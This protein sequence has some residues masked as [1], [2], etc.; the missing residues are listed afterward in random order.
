MHI[1]QAILAT[2]ASPKPLVRGQIANILSVIAKIEIPREEWN[3]LVP[4]LCN[5]STS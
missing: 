1:K 4:N 3:D 5:N 2:L